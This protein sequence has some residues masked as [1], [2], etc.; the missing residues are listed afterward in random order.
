MTEAKTQ[1][2]MND[3]GFARNRMANLLHTDGHAVHELGHEAHMQHEDRH[4][5]FHSEQGAYMDAEANLRARLLSMNPETTKERLDS[6]PM[7]MS[8]DAEGVDGPVAAAG[9]Y[10]PNNVPVRVVINTGNCTDPHFWSEPRSVEQLTK[11]ITNAPPAL[12]QSLGFDIHPR[13]ASGLRFGPVPAAVA[14]HHFSPAQAEQIAR[15]CQ[16][17][18]VRG[19]LAHG[20]VGVMNVEMAQ[21]ILLR[22]PQYNRL[23]AATDQTDALA[24]AR[25]RFDLSKAV[26][27]RLG[28][29]TAQTFPDNF[30]DSATQ[31]GLLLADLRDVNGG[32]RFDT[33]VGRVRSQAFLDF[34]LTN[35]AAVNAARTT[36]VLNGYLSQAQQARRDLTSAVNYYTQIEN[37][38]IEAD[39]HLARLNPVAV[40]APYS[41]IITSVPGT[42][43]PTIVRAQINSGLN[44]NVLKNSLIAPTDDG[45]LKTPDVY[46]TQVME[47]EKTVKNAE[48]NRPKGMKAVVD[49]YTEYY[50]DKYK[51][52]DDEAKSR[53]YQTFLTNELSLQQ[54]RQMDE[55]VETLAGGK[56]TRF[57][58]AAKG[59]SANITGL[60]TGSDEAF[61]CK[62]AESKDVGIPWAVGERNTPGIMNAIPGLEAI[63]TIG[64]LGYGTAA[65]L[66]GPL[67]WAAAGVGT[68]IY[69]L[70]R[71]NVPGFRWLHTA[72]RYLSR[73]LFGTRYFGIGWPRWRA[74][75]AWGLIANNRQKLKI[76]WNALLEGKK[77]GKLRNTWYVQ[78][79]MKEI[80]HMLIPELAKEV[81]EEMILTK[82]EDI[83][84]D[85]VTAENKRAVLQER[86]DKMLHEGFTEEEATAAKSQ[87]THKHTEKLGSTRKK[88]N[89]T[90]LSPSWWKKKVDGWWNEP[91]LKRKTTTKKD[92]G[93]GKGHHDHAHSAHQA[94]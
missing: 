16:L 7:R 10:A 54:K 51:L 76:V 62:I 78:E 70:G 13:A 38:L 52:S 44:L 80:A 31:L 8:F 94:A 84:W 47:L 55:E 77:T 23:L 68:G 12:L 4:T 75:P 56:L 25:A 5:V 65:L 73:N 14:F 29:I 88:V 89:S 93:H 48:A 53:A 30:E 32:A 11:I 15:Q 90:V 27:E 26:H 50:K 59:L 3:V 58:A 41:T 9:G 39:R 36:N 74:R 91:G 79:T 6:A 18:Y 43:P 85:I 87:D 63:T 72:G 34:G 24:R 33:P 20:H 69:A 21:R 83:N 45:G 64:A 22:H 60:F 82:Q 17:F 86:I 37:A 61:I 92:D 49:I 46:Q 1:I 28:A 67:G 2:I 81:G 35:E 57:A 40:G 19:R 71:S 66:G 42:I